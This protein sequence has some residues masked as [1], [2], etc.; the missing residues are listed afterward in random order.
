MTI[1]VLRSTND[2][3]QNEMMKLIRYD[4][5]Q[6]GAKKS[7][8]KEGDKETNVVEEDTPATQSFHFP[9]MVVE[10]DEEVAEDDDLL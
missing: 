4:S 1:N 5:A 3:G 10:D 8:W 2:K 6:I 7:D 9:S